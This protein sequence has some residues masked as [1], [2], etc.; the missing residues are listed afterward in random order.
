MNTLLTSNMLIEQG[1]EYLHEGKWQPVTENHIGLQVY[2]APSQIRRPSPLSAAPYENMQQMP[3]TKTTESIPS[4][5]QEQTGQRLRGLREREN[6]S[7]QAERTLGKD[8]AER[9]PSSAGSGWSKGALRNDVETK[10]L[11]EVPQR[12]SETTTAR[13]PSRSQESIPSD[14]AV[15][16]LPQEGTFECRDLVLAEPPRNDTA[17]DPVQ[18]GDCE[19]ARNCGEARESTTFDRG[20]VIRTPDSRGGAQPI[21]LPVIVKGIPVHPDKVKPISPDSGVDGDSVPVVNTAKA[22]K[23]KSPAASPSAAGTPSPGIITIPF[24]APGT[25]P[26]TGRNGTFNGKAIEFCSAFDGTM[27]QM[28][29]VGKRGVGN[30]L[31][32]FPTSIIPQIV[33]W[34]LRQQTT[35]TT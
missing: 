31:I 18:S 9:T 7:L 32:S 19:A 14:M 28:F 22:E 13:T 5:Q 17:L 6:P 35:K 21:Q 16:E 23:D 15:P 34:L 25:W 27:I 26:W 10:S 3:S 30:C 24:G 20:S 12:I 4:T 33:D 2:F 11:P 29:P 8:Q 1:D